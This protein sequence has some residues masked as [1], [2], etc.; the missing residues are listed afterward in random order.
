MITS[1]STQ[2]LTLLP[3]T[4]NP[5]SFTCI[6]R[7]YLNTPTKECTHLYPS[8]SASYL[9][10][11][12]FLSMSGQLWCLCN[13]LPHSLHFFLLIQH[14]CIYDR[15]LVETIA[16]KILSCLKMWWYVVSLSPILFKPY[17]DVLI[18]AYDIYI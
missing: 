5:S 2:P 7:N 12:N 3:H 9:L 6:T 1:I 17:V 13:N 8:I 11:K 10:Y 16:I 4:T 15:G 14:C 18:P